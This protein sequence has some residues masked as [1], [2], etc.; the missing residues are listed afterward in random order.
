MFKICEKRDELLNLGS[1]SVEIQDSLLPNFN[2][3]ADL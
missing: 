2:R 1:Q 3:F